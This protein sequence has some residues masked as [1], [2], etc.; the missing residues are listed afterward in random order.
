MYEL[1]YMARF[2]F[3]SN[4]IVSVCRLHNQAHKKITAPAT[5]FSDY[6]LITK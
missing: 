2:I 4:T 3:V 1:C 5:N 6:F